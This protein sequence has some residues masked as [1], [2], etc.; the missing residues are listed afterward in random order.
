MILRLF[1]GIFIG[2]FSTV[3]LAND[4][5]LPC[6]NFHVTGL[7]AKVVKPF[8]EKLK[9]NLIKKDFKALAKQSDYIFK[10]NTRKKKFKLKNEKEFLEQV[11]KTI[12][13]K[14][15]QNVI[16]ADAKNSI[17]NSQGVGLYNGYLW[18]TAPNFHTKRDV[19]KVI[20]INVY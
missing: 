1:I 10:L 16:A 7:N 13:D 14:W 11:P 19:L 4:G 5:A 3:V 15:L 6:E 20:S 17:C 9:K 2:I 8:I 18:I 12:N